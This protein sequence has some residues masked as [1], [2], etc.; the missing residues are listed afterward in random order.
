MKQCTPRFISAS[1]NNVSR[2][3]AELGTTG[4]RALWPNTHGLWHTAFHGLPTHTHIPMLMVDNH[5][6]IR[7]MIAQYNRHLMQYT[8][9]PL[10]QS[11]DVSRLF[12]H[13]PHGQHANDGLIPAITWFLE[14]IYNLPEYYGRV[15]HM[16]LPNTHTD[17]LAPPPT[18][19][20]HSPRHPPPSGYWLHPCTYYAH[21]THAW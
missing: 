11:A 14:Y 4:L 21:F 15:P 13:I 18:V 7:A 1:F 9:A 20:W 10:L 8:H 17:M 16:P 19:A 3:A 2:W 5:A 12:T 6:G